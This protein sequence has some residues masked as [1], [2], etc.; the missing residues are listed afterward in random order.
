VILY[1]GLAIGI[2]HAFL[3]MKE[4]NKALF[5]IEEA[6]PNEETYEKLEPYFTSVLMNLF[7]FYHI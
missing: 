2:I 5:K 4:W 7:N 1:V 6:P 3:P